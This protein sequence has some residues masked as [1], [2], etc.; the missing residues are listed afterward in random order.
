NVMF[1]VPATE[2]TEDKPLTI[3]QGH[4]DMVAAAEDGRDFDPLEDSITV[5]RDDE[6]GI[7]AADGTSLGADDGSD[8]SIIMAA[9]QGKMAHG[10]LRVII[11]ADE[12]DSMAGAF[13]MD[14][15]WFEGATY[16]INID[17]E[18]SSQVLVSTAAGD[19]VHVTKKVAFAAP[20]ESVALAIGVSGLKGGYSGVEIDKG[21]LNGIMGLAGLLKQLDEA[22][23]A[24]ELASFTGGTAGNAIR[25]KAQATIVVNAD[26]VAAVEQ[27]A[28]A[29]LDAAKTDY[30]D[31]EN[32][33]AMKCTV[34]K[35]ESLPNVVSTED[36]DAL[37]TLAITAVNGVH[38]MSADK[39]GLV[40]SSS[41]FG[42]L[43]LDEEGLDALVTVRS[44]VGE[45]ETEL[46]EAHKALAQEIGC[47]VEVTKLADPWPYD[48]SNKLTELG[49]QVYQKLNGEEI[50]V[51][52]VHGGL[53]C[54]TFKVLKP[55]LD[56]I[57]IGPDLKD[58]HTP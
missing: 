21:R 27:A 20:S 55:D 22:G 48:P 47:E 57:S 23:I 38:T 50:E 8:V 37:I 39:E 9:V 25:P 1:D 32:V 56:M 45:K 51:A 31:I 2:G 52:A 12:E 42:I 49:K 17:N 7:L 40:E 24:F 34:T 11:T 6:E 53:E 4:M 29:W 41:N 43:K 5:I 3:L 10:P 46:V 28:A 19:S 54:G 58:V 44:S 13:G 35:A 30:A 33:D 36:R 14:A 26:A 18:D 15:S 16:L